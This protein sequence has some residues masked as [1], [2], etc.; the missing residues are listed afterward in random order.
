MKKNPPTLKAPHQKECTSNPL[1]EESEVNGASMVTITITPNPAQLL[2][3]LTQPNCQKK[4]YP[5]LSV[6][7]SGSSVH[8]YSMGNSQSKNYNIYFSK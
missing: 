1:L 2:T 6:N 8:L 4:V 5:F 3:R 7:T